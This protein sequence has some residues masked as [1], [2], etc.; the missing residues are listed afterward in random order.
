MVTREGNRR[1]Q[2]QLWSVFEPAGGVW[3]GIA[4]VPNGNLRLRERFAAHDA[5]RYGRPCTPATP[6]G[7]CM[8]SAEGTCRIWSEYGEHGHPRLERAVPIARSDQSSQSDGQEI[9]R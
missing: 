2:E 8:V 3:R 5:R 7:A 4:R 9:A 6:I 1:A